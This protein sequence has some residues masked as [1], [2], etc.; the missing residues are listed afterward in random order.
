M[1][2]IGRLT[3]ANGRY[4][5]SLEELNLVVRGSHAEWVLEAATEIIK[6]T[7]R[8]NL[9]GQISEIE[10]LMEMGEADEIDLDILK[11]EKAERFER[12]PQCVVTM[13]DQDYRWVAPEGR[14]AAEDGPDSR[15][16]LERLIDQSKTRS[17]SFLNNVDGAFDRAPNE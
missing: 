8:V 6:Q 3:K 12:M 16:M 10:T 11:D 4:E 17:D 14:E 2:D 9:D 7:T 1:D 15:Q 13:G 5:F